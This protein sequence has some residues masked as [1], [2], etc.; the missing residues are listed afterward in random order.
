[1]HCEITSPAGKTKTIRG[2]PAYT[3]DTLLGV[4]GIEDDG[5]AGTIYR[6]ASATCVIQADNEL[7]CGGYDSAAQCTV[8]PAEITSI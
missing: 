1:M 6:M 7:L 3:L 4:A 8:A 2:V 5:A